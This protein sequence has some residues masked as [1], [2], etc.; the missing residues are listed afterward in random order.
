M[1]LDGLFFGE[2][3]LKKA[4]NEYVEHYD[5]E[6]N[7]QGLDNF[8]PFPYAGQ[9]KGRSGSV[10][11]FERLG[12]LLNYYHLEKERRNDCPD[13]NIRKNV[14]EIKIDVIAENPEGFTSA[15]AVSKG[16][17]VSNLLGGRPRA[18]TPRRTP[19]GLIPRLA[20]KP[21]LKEFR[22]VG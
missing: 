8:I 13:R 10:V 18:D 4:V 1:R 16:P 3:S 6:R 2:H 5:H 17:L 20:F 7:H 11:K 19:L 22:P 12:G 9:T 21:A 15:V 14:I